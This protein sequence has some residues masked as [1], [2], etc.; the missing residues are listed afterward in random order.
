[1][2]L[3]LKGLPRFVFFGLG[4]AICTFYHFKIGWAGWMWPSENDMITA[5]FLTNVRPMTHLTKPCS[6]LKIDSSLYVRLFK[7]YRYSLI[8]RHVL[9]LQWIDA[10]KLLFNSVIFQLL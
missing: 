7:I 5:L 8:R 4:G 2:E 3:I 6:I 10:V 1:M 9:I